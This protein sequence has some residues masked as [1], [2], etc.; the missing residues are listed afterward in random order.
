V[1]RGSGQG[2]R[3]GNGSKYA[4]RNALRRK[5]VEFGLPGRGNRHVLFS[6]LCSLISSC[7]N[8]SSAKGPKRGLFGRFL[9]KTT[10]ILENNVED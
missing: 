2:K 9:G 8:C 7:S 3:V 5:K 4:H 10:G 1:I 6:F